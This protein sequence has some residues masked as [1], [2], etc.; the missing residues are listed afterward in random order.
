M[1]YLLDTN[2]IV[3]YSR[4][5]EIA[6]RI[7]EKFQ[8]F[9]Q[10]NSLAISIVTLGELDALIKKLKLGEKRKQKIDRILNSVAKIGLNHKE[11]ISRYGD[12]DAFSQGK[13]RHSGVKFSSRNMGKNDMWIAA[14]ASAFELTLVTTDQ[15]F[16]H[17]DG[18]YINLE[19]IDIEEFKQRK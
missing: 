6:D 14:T 15:D 12:I 13:I 9:D 7:E 5:S 2:I 16:D 17:L 1:D 8:L 10:K 18:V 3:I 4:D 11:I 19:Q